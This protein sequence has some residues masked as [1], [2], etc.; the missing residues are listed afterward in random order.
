MNQNELRDLT[1]RGETIAVEFK[2]DRPKFGDDRIAEVVACLANAEGGILLIGVEDDGTITGAQARHGEVTNPLRLQALI[3]NK[4]VPPVVTD[5]D[6]VEIDGAAV[7]VIE[8]PRAASITGTSAGQYS[9]RGLGGDGR[10]ACLPLLAHEM[11]SSRIERGEVDYA[12]I[13]EPDAKVDDLDPSEFE[14]LRRLVSPTGGGSV[15]ASLSDVEIGKALGVIDGSEES[16]IIRRGALLLF[17]RDE[18]LRQFIPTHETAF[19]VLSGTA[20]RQ[21]VFSNAPLFRAAEDLYTQLMR[22]DEED[23]LDIGLTRVSVPR[24]PAVAARELIANA[25]VH[26]DYTMQG[27]V[28]LQLT[29]EELT[30]ANPG[31]LPRG[32]TLDNL[33]STS[34]PRSRILSE[35][36]FRA[37]IVERTGRGINRVFEST[38][39]A[40]RAAPDFSRTDAHHVVVTVPTGRA[41]LAVVRFLVAHTERRGRPFSLEELLVLHALQDDPRLTVGELADLVQRSQIATRTVLTRMVE[42][43][44]IEMRGNGRGRRYTMSAATYREIS[45]PAGYVRVRSFDTAQQ[46][47][48]VLTY[49]R[50]HGSITRA[51]AADLCALPSDAAKHLLRSL[52]DRGFL[53]LVGE[54]RAAHYVLAVE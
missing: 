40:G 17:G 32:V 31:G 33:L 6:V 22:Y 13:V 36:F 2:S 51:Q 3:S 24:I 53:R 12:S 35:A 23:E 41:D 19:Q 28:S 11:L 27:P 47:Q 20:V 39:R 16:P 26:R 4:T 9:R 21:N 42:E 52:R 8:I 29:E 14:R 18:R 5:V 15:L 38:L 45:S 37:G 54:R 10:P 46:E 49:V 44:L 48:M 34:Q 25:L 43:G 1:S 50:S 7:I 30:I